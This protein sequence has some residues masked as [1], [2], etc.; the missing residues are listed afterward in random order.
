[1][2]EAH[3]QR[4][5]DAEAAFHLAR[6][7]HLDTKLG[8]AEEAYREAVRIQPELGEAWLHLSEILVEQG[9]LEEA[10]ATLEGLERARGGG[11]N[12]DYQKGFILSK[13]GRFDAAQTFLRHSLAARPGNA[14]AWYGLGINAQRQGRDEEAAVAFSTALRHDPAY[15]DALFNLGNAMARLGRAAE[16]EQALARFAS[17][18]EAQEQGR[19]RQARLRTLRRGAEMDLQGERLDAVQRQIDEAGELAPALPWVARLQGELLL[20]RGRRPEAL[21][22][23]RQAAAL[24]SPDAAEH[25]ALA[26]ALRRAGDEEAA[27]HEEREARRLLARG[28]P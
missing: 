27:G 3:R 22:H 4:P 12:L 21:V 10:L 8:E 11:P 24:N 17:V 25:L 18:N 23:L 13:L 28:R 6:A 20:A 15:T 26:R 2:R 19:A 16:A 14:D 7:L 5:A 9:R 1:M